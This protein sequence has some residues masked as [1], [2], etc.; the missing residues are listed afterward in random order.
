MTANLK[1]RADPSIDGDLIGFVPRGASPK[2][3]S[4]NEYWVNVEYQGESGWVGAAYVS[5]DC[6]GMDNDAPAPAARRGRT[7]L[8]NGRPPSAGGCRRW[9]QTLSDL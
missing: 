6:S 9:M 2:P 8:H 1:L 4:R 7:Y 3:V 5:E